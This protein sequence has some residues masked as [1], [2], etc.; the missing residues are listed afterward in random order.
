MISTMWVV[1][2]LWACHTRDLAGCASLGD[3]IDREECRYDFIK[4]LVKDDAALRSAVD[5]VTEPASRDLVLLRLAVDNPA[6]AQALCAMVRLPATREKCDKV[7]GRPHI[8]GPRPS[9]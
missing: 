5:S 6:R 2:S 3:P 9:P 8:A 4:P 7:I 1:L